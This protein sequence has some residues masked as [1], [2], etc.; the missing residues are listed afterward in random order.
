MNGCKDNMLRLNTEC[1]DKDDTVCITTDLDWAPEIAIERTL[2]FFDK[3]EIRPT[4]FVTHKSLVIEKWKGKIDLGIHPNFIQ[5]SSQG[6]DIK[7]I[8]DFCKEL[9]PETK[10]FRCHRW[11]ASNDIYDELW[12]RGFKYESNICTNLDVVRPFVHR[13]GMICFPAFFEDGGYI[14][15]GMEL[16]YNVFSEAFR[17][18]GLKVINIHPMHF[19]LNTPYF[20][21]TRDI[22]DN[23][24][25]EEWNGLDE[26]SLGRIIY[27]GNGIRNVLEDMIE[28]MKKRGTE[29]ITLEEAYK[30]VSRR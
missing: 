6:N 23:L 25:R 8:L 15:S 11:Y 9:A 24:S 7:S 20:K 28:D 14:K 17:T 10:C 27:R 12:E 3:Y 13:S 5:P 21:Y 16:N 26:E 29:I 22:K 18:K 2:S 19:V 4:V 1:F 30:R